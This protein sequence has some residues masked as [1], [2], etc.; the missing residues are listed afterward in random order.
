MSVDIS[1][2]IGAIHCHSLETSFPLRI[3]LH[4]II[5]GGRTRHGNWMYCPQRCWGYIP[6]SSWPGKGLGLCPRSPPRLWRGWVCVPAPLPGCEGI[7]VDFILPC[8][9]VKVLGLSPVF[10]SWPNAALWRF[11]PFWHDLELYLSSISWNQSLYVL[12]CGTQPSQ[13]TS[14]SFFFSSVSLSNT[15]VLFSV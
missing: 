3:L 15:Q 13:H 12:R 9:T 6:P 1:L 7:G 5:L 2:R 14:I 8:W 4:P 11:F 10:F